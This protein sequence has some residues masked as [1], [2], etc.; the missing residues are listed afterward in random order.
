MQED[1]SLSVVIST[2]SDAEA[3][4]IFELVLH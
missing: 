4:A 3:L 2:I 1:D